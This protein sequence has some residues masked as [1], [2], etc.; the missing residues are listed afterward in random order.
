[1]HGHIYENHEV[2]PNYWRVCSELD[3]YALYV[4]LTGLLRATGKKLYDL[5]RTQVV[6]SVIARQAEDG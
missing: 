4:T 5:L 2:W 6:F 1:M 3:A